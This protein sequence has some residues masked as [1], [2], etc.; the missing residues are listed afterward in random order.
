RLAARGPGPAANLAAIR[1]VASVLDELSAR[2]MPA[3]IQLADTVEL[4]Q[5]LPQQARLEL[6]PLEAAAPAL[7]QADESIRRSIDRVAALDTARLRPEV[8]DGVDQ[9]RAGLARVGALVG[10]AAKAS[11]VLPSMLG[12]HGPRTI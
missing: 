3:V 12:A 8:R 9:L 5:L 6:A 7:V 4:G 10:A 11:Q 1:V 2:A